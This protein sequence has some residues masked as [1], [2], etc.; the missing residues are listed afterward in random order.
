[1]PCVPRKSNADLSKHHACHAKCKVLRDFDD[2]CVCVKDCVWQS[3]VRKIV[4]VCVLLGRVWKV[5]CV[6]VWQSCVWKIVCDKVVRVWLLFALNFLGAMM[7]SYRLSNLWGPSTWFSGSCHMVWYFLVTMLESI[8]F[9]ETAGGD[10]VAA[11]LLPT[12]L[13]AVD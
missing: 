10:R 2:V 9:F 6:C 5:V 8:R 13:H 12:K 11:W 7:E 1:M 3:C 4:C